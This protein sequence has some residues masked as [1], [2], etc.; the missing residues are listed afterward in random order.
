MVQA[1][2]LDCLF[3]DFFPFSKNSL[4]SPFFISYCIRRPSWSLEIP[5]DAQVESERLF[6]PLPA[7]PLRIQSYQG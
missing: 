5:L 1:A 3:F 4:S 2:L 7:C 6:Y